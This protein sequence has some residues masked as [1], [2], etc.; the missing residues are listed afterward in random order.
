[1]R[2]VAPQVPV[3]TEYFALGGGLDQLTP[4][5]RVGNG[6]LLDVSNYEPAITG[7]YQRTGG[8]ERFD[9]RARPSDAAVSYVACTITTPLTAGDALVIGAATCTFVKTVTG[10]M[11]VTAVVGTIPDATTITRTAVNVGSTAASAESS[12][13]PTAQAYATDLNDAA[14]IYRALIAKVPG[15]GAVRGVFWWRSTC[16]AVRDNAGATAA[17]LHKSTASGW[18][19]ITLPFELAFT[20][21]G[22]GT[23]AVG[24]T[25]RGNTSTAT[26]TILAIV[27]E[28]GQFSASSAAGRLIITPLTGTFQAAESLRSSVDAYATNR[29]TCSGAATAVTIPAGGNYQFVR[30]NFYGQMDQERIYGVSGVT[31]G[32][33]FDGT[34][35]VPIHTGAGSTIDKPTCISAHKNCLFF[36]IQSSLIKSAPGDPYRYLATDFGA[37]FP[38]GSTITDLLSNV[39]DALAIGCTVKLA[40]LYGSSSTDFLID[41]IDFTG[42]VSFRSMQTVGRTFYFG[43][44]GV[45]EMAAVQEFGNFSSSSASQ[46]IQKFID[47]RR[48]KE[49]VSCVVRDRNQFRLYWDDGRALVLLVEGK[50]IKG[51]GVLDMPVAFTCLTS[52]ED[53]NGVERVLAG[54]DDGYV[55]ELNRGSSFDGAEI[56][57][58]F[59]TVF[60][61][62]RSPRLRKRYRRLSIDMTSELYSAIRLQATLSFG[63]SDVSAPTIQDLTVAGG[64]A[65]W[66]QGNWDEF[67]W[68]SQVITQPV[69]ELTGTGINVAFTF[70]QSSAIDFGH[71]IQGLVV[72]W[73]ARRNERS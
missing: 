58:R 24:Q 17:V 38:V 27:T 59:T 14:T 47:G 7:G 4:A 73:T 33:E 22:T 40:A 53:S 30:H 35:Y 36:G 13:S 29:A 41:T 51:F 42:S 63:S 12:Y 39:G 56:E 62:S 34:T 44:R 46:N 26:G 66:D 72:H 1:M 23:F 64:G 50:N 37:E 43:S 16:Y 54:T 67:F 48:G 49:V 18:S 25:V 57:C 69:V 61:H 9:G 8:Y 65:L 21:G 70:Y 52:E 5:L 11:A 10:G 31:Y 32:F 3:Q 15:S 2:Y 60:N 68:D 55:V 19:A 71:V 45:Q 28:S 20:A 6:M